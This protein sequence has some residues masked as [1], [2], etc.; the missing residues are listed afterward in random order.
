MYMYACVTTA[1]CVYMRY[2]QQH[3]LTDNDDDD[4]DDDDDV[5]VASLLLQR[6]ESHVLRLFD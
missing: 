4:D 6:G 5:F 1:V 2:Q 3:Q